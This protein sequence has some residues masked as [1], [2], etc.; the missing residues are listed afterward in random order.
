MESQIVSNKHNAKQYHMFEQM[1][2]ILKQIDNNKSTKQNGGNSKYK[3]KLNEIMFHLSNG[4]K[5]TQDNI[6]SQNKH[7]AKSLMLLNEYKNAH[8]KNM[9]GGNFEQFESDYLISIYDELNTFSMYAKIILENIIDHDISTL[10]K[11]ID[12]NHYTFVEIS[13]FGNKHNLTHDQIVDL[14]DELKRNIK[15]FVSK[16]RQSY[17]MSHILV[18]TIVESDDFTGCVSKILFSGKLFHLKFCS[19]NM[20]GYI[21][22][23]RLIQ[24]MPRI[25]LF[26]ES[27]GKSTVDNLTRY[28][29]GP[30]AIYDI[31]RINMSKQFVH[32]LHFASKGTLRPKEC[33]TFVPMKEL[34]ISGIHNPTDMDCFYRSISYVLTNSEQHYEKFKTRLLGMLISILKT[35][36]A[37]KY[38]I[39]F[40]DEH[41]IKLDKIIENKEKFDAIF[42]QTDKKMSQIIAIMETECVSFLHE[43]MKSLTNYQFDRLLKT[44]ELDN[45]IFYELLPIFDII[46]DFFIW[47]FGTHGF[48]IDVEYKSTTRYKFKML[49]MTAIKDIAFVSTNIK[50]LSYPTDFSIEIPLLVSFNVALDTTIDDI[51]CEKIASHIE[52]LSDISNSVENDYK[53][54]FE[55]TSVLSALKMAHQPLSARIASAAAEMDA[56]PAIAA[57]AI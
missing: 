40:G 38:N 7:Y 57:P 33:A 34:W 23:N 28:L 19:F 11:T 8:S 5:L 22:Q 48:N 6:K 53:E 16:M 4:K 15:M 35:N 26:D 18:K 43:Y 25:M 3:H 17:A 39:K 52:V 30:D 45:G 46:V 21:V 1:Q 56:H 20:F 31:E 50:Q 9:I 47:R 41:K 13:L 54:T 12:A 29:L 37:T 51:D 36:F 42:E 49:F 32:K 2:D 55:E 10:F 24:Y 27:R 44:F 14:I